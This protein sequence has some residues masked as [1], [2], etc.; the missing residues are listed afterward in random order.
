MQR[1]STKDDGNAATMKNSRKISCLFKYLQDRMIR[2]YI[3]NKAFSMIRILVFPDIINFR[4]ID[5]AIDEYLS[6]QEPIESKLRPLNRVAN[7]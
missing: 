1:K 6:P 2:K 3:T 4:K 5:S 7:T